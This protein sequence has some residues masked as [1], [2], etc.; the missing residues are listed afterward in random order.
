MEVPYM[1]KHVKCV[2]SGIDLA[3][4]NCVPYD[5]LKNS[6][7]YGRLRDLPAVSIISL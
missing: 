5:L 6:A 7:C 2:A 4:F 1:A 3:G